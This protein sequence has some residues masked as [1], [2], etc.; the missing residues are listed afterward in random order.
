MPQTDIWLECLLALAR[1]HH[2]TVSPSALTAGLPLVEGRLTPELFLRAAER[3]G[4]KA[5]QERCAQDK[6]GDLVLP[7]VLRKKD[8]G[9][10][11]L[12]AYGKAGASILPVG[13]D[14]A[15]LMP[16]AE[17]MALYTGEAIVVEPAHALDAR[18]GETVGTDS[19][20]WFWRGMLAN[21][22]IYFDVLLA[23]LFINL[24][25]IA[26]PLY[27]MNVYDRVVPNQA[28]E[29]L[30][31]LT[32]GVLL[33]LVFDFL[34]RMLRAYF[35]DIAGKRVDTALSATLFAHV[36]AVRPAQWPESSGSL[37]SSMREFETLRDFV[38]S[39]TM[40]TL[41]DLPFLFLFIGV[42]WVLGSELALIPLMALPLVV[43]AG[44]LLQIPLA[45]EAQK[46]YAEL[47]QKQAL[48][49][50]A[51]E[52]MEAIKAATAEGAVQARWEGICKRGA[53]SGLR[54]RLISTLMLNF[55]ATV[56]Q[57]AYIATVVGGVFLIA[58][59]RMTVGSLIA[60]SILVSRGLAPVGQVAS[61]MSRFQS[62]RAALRGLDKLM[63][64][65]SERPEGRCF[66]HRPQLAGDIVFEQV[67]FRYPAQ[68]GQALKD[69][70]FK[71]AAGERV[72]ILGKV[73]SGKSTLQRLV[74]GL[75]HPD[76]GSVQ[77]DGSD[78]RQID[79]ADLRRNISYVSQEPRLFYGTLRENIALGRPGAS[80]DQVLAAARAAG[81]DAF[82]KNHPS[83]YDM[84]IGEGGKGLSGGQRQAVNIARA[85]M[86]EPPIL[87][88]DE[89]TGPMDFNTEQAFINAMRA[90]LPGRTLLLVTHKP[91]MLVLVDRIIVLDGGTIVADG[92]RD[93]IMQAFA[94][95][96]T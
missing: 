69:V 1:L 73:G 46:N 33:V 31:A 43:V 89:P 6:L 79:P 35:L 42:I 96:P 5:M 63:Q 32:I 65:E 20:D 60:C 81:V 37:S 87:L 9:A 88:F 48:L 17:V 80:D 18:A 95:K 55:T 47:A 13:S 15:V 92:P 61:L 66:L 28:L 83:G 93:K 14:E 75:Y 56:Q 62:S 22:R 78:V 11:L 74:L 41:V 25:T 4:L 53:E 68:Q 3:A 91:S 76:S 49:V 7:A 34:L 23:A 19:G 30:W 26:T 2:R 90:Y 45:R 77:V 72:A 36:L 67:N 85:L 40:T 50:E 84:A 86:G 58:Q 44:L 16:L 64:L 21:R 38:T 82:I 71:V 12:T 51:V 10:L 54:S 59:N 70:S 52:G 94:A 24:F 39:A 57:L 27:V 29:T 8:G